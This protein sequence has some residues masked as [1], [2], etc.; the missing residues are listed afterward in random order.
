[1][2]NNKL[3]QLAR[4]FAADLS[5]LLNST[6]TDGI[7]ITATTLPSGLVLL[8]RGI[9]NSN[10]TS[11]PIPLARSRNRPRVYLK[12]THWCGL[13]DED[14]HLATITSLMDLHTSDE[15]S[16]E[17]LLLG[18]D[19]S[20]YPNNEFPRAHMHVAGE[21]DDLDDL[22]LGGDKNRRTLRQLHLP[23]GGSRYRPT[24]EDL[25]EFVILEKMAKP[26]RE[27]KKAIEEHRGRWEELQLKA[28][29]RRS[30]K[31]AAEELRAAG[32]QI[33]EQPE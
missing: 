23:V 1:M 4:Q 31:A 19:Y 18:I 16:N 33:T 14:T 28:A 7:R 10:L 6:I 5:D 30:Q 29:V 9:G 2:Q 21:R 20:R 11:E 25:L 15:I 24:L 17:S 3:V 32:W 22:Y 12:Y 27:W 8:G 13:D 26:R